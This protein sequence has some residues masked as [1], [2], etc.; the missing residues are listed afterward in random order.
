M[1]EDRNPP[2]EVALVL[3]PTVEIDEER[4]L[5]TTGKERYDREL[6]RTRFATSTLTVAAFATAE[7]VPYSTAVRYSSADDWDGARRKY[8]MDRAA[9]S[10]KASLERSVKVETELDEKAHHA[11]VKLTEVAAG[12]LKTVSDTHEAS[13]AAK[14]PGIL[15]LHDAPR[16][17]LLVETLEKAHRLARITAHLPAEPLPTAGLDVDLKKLAP[18]KQRLLHELLEEARVG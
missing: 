2:S 16:L 7:D 6:L 3:V 1:S 15:T 5:A 10:R 14:G 4:P 13:L 12:I 11:A 9:E 17:K 8:Q 18:E